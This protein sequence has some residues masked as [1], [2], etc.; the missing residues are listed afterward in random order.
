MNAPRP[1]PAV[2]GERA[3]M[4][5]EGSVA[6]CLGRRLLDAPVSGEEIERKS[7]EAIEAEKVKG[8]LDEAQ[9][10]VARR[11]IHACGDPSIVRTLRF[12]G[13]WLES[14]RSALRAREPV[15]CDASMARAGLSGARLARATGNGVA[16]EIV[17]GVADPDVAA[18]A[19]AT[20]L[21]RSVWAVR[22]AAERLGGGGIWLFG[23]APTALMELVRLHLEEGYR[24]SLVL[25]MP[26]GFVH[27]VES[28]AEFVEVGLPGI[29]VAGRRGGTPLVVAALHA[30]CALAEEEP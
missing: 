26:V 21:P 25:A 16:P 11:M 4:A 30:I 23:N 14:G 18:R 2:V 28:K 3:G 20:G 22:K 24:P 1:T 12:R 15:C 10:V 5:G 27:V 7:F 13:D 19:A 6:I 9:W 17:C 8:D 29:A